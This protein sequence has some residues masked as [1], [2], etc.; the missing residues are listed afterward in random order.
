M[1]KDLGLYSVI[2]ESTKLK[3]ILTGNLLTNC[4]V[5]KKYSVVACAGA[6]E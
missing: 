4:R 1:L 3:A 2:R 6:S 5:S